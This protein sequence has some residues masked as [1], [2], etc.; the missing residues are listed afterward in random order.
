M[1]TKMN[2]R[3]FYFQ[4]FVHLPSKNEKWINVFPHFIE[5][6]DMVEFVVNTKQA[7]RTLEPFAADQV[8]KFSSPVKSG[9]QQLGNTTCIQFKLSDEIK[10]FLLDRPSLGYWLGDFPE[11]PALFLDG[12]A[13]MWTISHDELAFFDL[14]DAEMLTF[15]NMGFSLERTDP[16]YPPP[17]S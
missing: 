8:R 11:D 10:R 16:L 6:A 13:L 17:I 14:T 9:E 12:T 5:R 15:C 4:E 7:L 1:N 2:P 3:S